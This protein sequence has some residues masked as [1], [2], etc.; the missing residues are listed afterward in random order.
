MGVYLGNT[1]ISKGYIGE[2]L[3]ES[4]T[5]N[6]DSIWFSVVGETFQL[7]PTIKPSDAPRKTITRASDDNTIATVDNTGLVTCVSLGDCNITATTV[8]GLT[9]TCAVSESALPSTYQ[10]VERIWST[11]SQYINTWFY[12]SVNTRIETTLAWDSNYWWAVFFGVTGND[13]SQDWILW[14]IY[15]DSA[16]VFNPW[17]CNANYDETTVTMSTNVFHDIVLASNTVEVDSVS[18]SI[19]TSWTPYLGS[20]DLFGWNNGGSHGWRCSNC[21]I[22]KFT[23]LENWVKE[24]DFIPCYRIADG[25]IWMYDIVYWVFYTNN[26]GWTFNKWPD[27]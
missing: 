6:K 3:P 5:L 18:Y 2:L 25:V 4:I 26:W 21:Q 17:F 23:I 20:I 7:I 11:R 10:E 27:V 9:A 24:R 14:R 12:P 16:G 1:E 19:T 22:K 15:A 13:S 8:N